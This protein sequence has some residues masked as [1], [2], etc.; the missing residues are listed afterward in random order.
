LLLSELVLAIMAEDKT[1]AEDVA[2]RLGVPKTMI[3]NLRS[4]A[5]TDMSLGNFVKLTH[6]YGYDLILE[7]AGERI[8]L[9]AAG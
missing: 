3:D 4:G 9:Q 5:Q 1:S 6:T 2:K 8:T 7:K